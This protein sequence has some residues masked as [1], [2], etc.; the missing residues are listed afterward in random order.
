MK[1]KNKKI[2]VYVCLLILCISVGYAALSTT[3]NITGVSNIKSAKWDVHFDNLKVN[4]DSVTATSPAVIDATKT[5]V[6]YSVSLL[7][8]GDSYSFTVDVVN[9][10]TIDAMVSVVSNTG[11]SDEQKKYV[12]YSVTYSNGL[13]VNTK[14]SLNAGDKRK[15]K[16]EVRYRTDLSASDLPNEDK[17]LDLT[18]K[19]TYV[20]ADDSKN[21]VVTGSIMETAVTDYRSEPYRSKVTKII[22]SGKLV[23]PDN[24]VEKWD[25]SKNKDGSVMA[26]AE[27]D[28]NGGYVVTICS[29]GKTYLQGSYASFF[30]SFSAVK[31]IDL[32]NFD[33]SMVTSMYSMFQGCSNLSN[34]NLK[35]LNTSKVTDMTAVFC[36]CS[37]LAV[38]D[39]SGFDTKNVISMTAMFYNCNGLINI[40][41]SNFNTSNVTSMNAM[42]YNCNGLIN[43]DL[44]NFNTS[45]VTSMNAMFTNC[46]SLAS[47]NIKNFNTSKVTSFG[48]MFT[49]LSSII[50]LDLSGL[51]FHSMEN[52]NGMFD[53]DSNLKTINLSN[54]NF[55]GV[56]YLYKFL[57]GAPAVKNLD[58]SGVNLSGVSG[59]SYDFSEGNT[60]LETINFSG[61]NFSSLTNTQTMFYTLSNIKNV[62]MSNIVAPKLT[63]I[64]AMFNSCSALETVDFRGIDT[65]KL[66]NSSSVFN[67]V[68]GAKIYVSSNT[69]KTNIE[70]MLTASSAT[71]NVLVK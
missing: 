16:V 31:S 55:S 61:A 48:G 9:A 33:T 6:N 10:G 62:N 40:D 63:N 12:S 30:Y 28:G 1:N 66:T 71:A 36:D 38:L 18:F 41:L 65:S 35:G 47:L 25:V 45:N 53:G 54:A 23:V 67:N 14:D 70:N 44:S 15:L 57:G 3:L 64:T 37:S 46:S 19:V 39:L 22:T 34:L 32:S 58:L 42:F 56:K 26:Y 11:L 59:I 24:V 60:V 20:Q 68:N 52:V 50:S 2:I 43:I 51:D 17:P 69:D 4:N 8:P 49:G 27:D 13:E 7:K 29:D 5:A 21:D